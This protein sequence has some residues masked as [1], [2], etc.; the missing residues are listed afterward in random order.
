VITA[1]LDKFAIED[2]VE[3][4]FDLDGWTNPLIEQLTEQYEEDLFT[5]NRIP[6]VELLAP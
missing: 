1:F 4:E 3:E 6:G 2:M 5:I